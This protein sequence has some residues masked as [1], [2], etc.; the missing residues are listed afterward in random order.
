ML[1]APR[2]RP[3]DRVRFIPVEWLVPNRYKTRI[4]DDSGIGV[5]FGMSSEL[6]V[7]ASEHLGK[8]GQKTQTMS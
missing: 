7:V 4:A 8:K 5:L 3:G 2:L 1:T 6:G